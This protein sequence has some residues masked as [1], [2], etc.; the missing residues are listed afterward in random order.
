MDA[1]HDGNSSPTTPEQGIAFVEHETQIRCRF[2]ESSFGAG[3]LVAKK[4]F[5][6]S[7]PRTKNDLYAAFVERG[8]EASAPRAVCS[9]PSHHA[10]ASFCRAFRNGARISYSTEAPPFVFADLGYRGS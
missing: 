8:V 10:Q 5:E 7:Y 1:A 3:T 9:A 6:K 2:D 4:E